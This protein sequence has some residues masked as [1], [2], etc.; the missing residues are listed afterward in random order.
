MRCRQELHQTILIKMQITETHL[1]PP[2]ENIWK[3]RLVLSFRGNT[4]VVLMGNT[5][6][7]RFAQLDQLTFWMYYHLKLKKWAHSVKL[8]KIRLNSGDIQS[9]L[10]LSFILF[11]FLQ[12]SN[13]EL[14]LGNVVK[15][16][17]L[18]TVLFLLLNYQRTRWE[19]LFLSCY[20]SET[21][22]Q[23]G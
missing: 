23:R 4:W 6:R 18:M 7:L 10:F 16:L 3:W 5:K 13:K 2:N 22:A 12:D 20:T 9:F 14:Y 11:F 21:V 15:S 1:W 19:H 17:L 8:H